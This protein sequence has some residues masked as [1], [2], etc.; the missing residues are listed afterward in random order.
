MLGEQ[1]LFATRL[2]N[3]QSDIIKSLVR[4]NGWDNLDEY[5]KI[6]A[7][8][9]FVQNEIL[10]G[11]NADDN[12][13]ATEVIADGIGQCNTKSTLLM[14]LLRAV[15]IP[16]RLHASK[17]SKE[18]QKG[19][20]NKFISALAPEYIIHTWVEVYFNTSWIS[21]EGVILD[22]SYLSAVQEKYPCQKGMFK[23]Y[24]IATN[25]FENPAVDW[26]GTDTFIQKE[27]VVFDYGV[28]ASP[29]EFF[30]QHRQALCFIKRF[31]YTHIGR[32]IMTM[33]VA[34]IRNQAANQRK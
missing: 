11:Y 30:S 15:N 1:Y 17:V 33:N 27:A 23:G 6:G 13:S 12:I 31:L 4:Y 25:C 32:R 2:L 29:D 24:A 20:I 5:T 26:K 28:F 3:Y 7:I 34:K 22:K 19:A 18:F 8:Y 14:A 21:L 9:S 16:C 10:F